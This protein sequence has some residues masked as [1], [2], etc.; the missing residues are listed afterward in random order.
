M[1]IMSL[2]QESPERWRAA[3]GA[4]KL[5]FAYDL[6]SVLQSFKMEIYLHSEAFTIV[7]LTFQ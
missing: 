7:Y 6:K 1:T 2:D 5:R 3:L 4:G